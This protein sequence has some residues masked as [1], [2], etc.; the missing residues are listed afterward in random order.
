MGMYESVNDITTS[1][2]GEI[3]LDGAQQ[4][5]DFSMIGRTGY[6]RQVTWAFAETGTGGRTLNARYKSSATQTA[7]ALYGHITSLRYKEA[8]MG[9][10]TEESQGSGSV[11]ITVYVHHTKTDGSDAQ[12]ITSASTTIDS[13]TSNPLAFDLG[14]D[15][16]GQTFTSADPRVLRVEVEVTGT[17]GGGSFTLAYD[18]PCASNACSSLDTPVVTVPEFGLAFAA[19]VAL[20]P[21]LMGGVWNRRRVAIRARKAHLPRPGVPQR[22]SP[23][24][25]RQAHLPPNWGA[26]RLGSGVRE[27]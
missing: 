5:E 6:N 3:R 10:G 14:N 24:R 8:S 25:A 1:T 2:A 27:R 7:H 12:L 9:L 22:S 15:P 26:T 13:G 23:R 17:S 16:V 18:G 20:I 11:D 19:L 4:T 21:A